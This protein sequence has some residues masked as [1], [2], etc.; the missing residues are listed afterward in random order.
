VRLVF[1]NLEYYVK[2]TGIDTFIFDWYWYEDAPYL[3]GALERGFLKADNADQ[4]RFALMWANHDWMD[5]FPAGEDRNYKVLTEGTVSEHQFVEA[6]DYMIA[7]YFHHPS[8]WRVGG[9]LYFSIYELMNLVKGLGGNLVEV[10]RILEDF[11][12]RVRSAGLGELHL[13]AIVWGIQNLPGE[14]A[15]TDVNGFMNKLGF[16]SI[17]SYV[18]IHHQEIPH[19]PYT[20]YRDYSELNVADYSKFTH[21]YILP[22]F[23]NVSMGWDSSP[24]TVQ[25]EKHE[26]IGYPYTPMLVENTPLTDANRNVSH[27]EMI[28]NKSL[29]HKEENTYKGVETMK[30]ILTPEQEELRKIIEENLAITKKWNEDVDRQ[31]M[32][33][34]FD[35]MKTTAHQLHMQLTPQLKHKH[36]MIENRNLQ[37]DHPEFYNHIHPVEDLIYSII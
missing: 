21:E 6:T 8:Y 31:I 36:Y 35:N 4:L 20:N 13:N 15:I 28:I 11:R 9:G 23:P 26:N 17:T 33:T 2:L 30:V 34:A 10:H 1:S 5:I 7:H 3:H 27:H 22:H 16:D 18:W 32:D 29:Q 19:Y 12:C 25:Q 24:R 14:E 37:P